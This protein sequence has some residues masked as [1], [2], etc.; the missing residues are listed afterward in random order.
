MCYPINT[1]YRADLHQTTFKA[2]ETIKFSQHHSLSSTKIDWWRSKDIL[3][4]TDP[5][6]AVLVRAGHIQDAVS[7]EILYIFRAPNLCHKPLRW[8]HNGLDGV[9][10]HQPRDCFLNCLFRRRSEKISKL[11]VT[12]VCTWNSLVTGEYSPQMASNAENVSIWWRHQAK[13]NYNHVNYQ[14]AII[15]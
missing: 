10:N 12:G 6:T 5:R 14:G 2:K 4:V 9:S 15:D 11:R 7:K 13:W 3:F 8:R 1:D